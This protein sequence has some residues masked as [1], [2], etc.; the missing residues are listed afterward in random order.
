MERLNLTRLREGTKEALAKKA[1][2]ADVL[3]HHTGEPNVSEY[4]HRV[5]EEHAGT[6]K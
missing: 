3:Y 6:R 5:L 1:K 4:A 2:K